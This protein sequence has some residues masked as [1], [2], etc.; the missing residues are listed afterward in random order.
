MFNKFCFY[1]VMTS[2]ILVWCDCPVFAGEG[3]ILKNETWSLKINP[4]TLELTAFWDDTSVVLSGGQSDLGGIEI[5]EQSDSRLIFNLS[6]KGIACEVRLKGNEVFIQL[7]ADKECEFSWPM[8]TE[9]PDL[10][11]LIFSRNEGIYVP[12][13]NKRWKDYL[14]EQGQWETMEAFSMPF[15]GFDCGGDMV[16]WIITNPYNNTINFS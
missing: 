4:Q 16:T 6:S 11:A 12:L 10:K 1:F 2:A 7:A 5:K 15:W 8:I 3:Y 14:A 9:S 13:D